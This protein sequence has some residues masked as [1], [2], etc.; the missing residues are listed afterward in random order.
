MRPNKCVLAPWRGPENSTSGSSQIVPSAC[1]VAVAVVYGRLTRF[2]PCSSCVSSKVQK[3]RWK[4]TSLPLWHL[5]PQWGQAAHLVDIQGDDVSAHL[6]LGRHHG[7]FLHFIPVGSQVGQPEVVVNKLKTAGKK[8]SIVCTQHKY[9]DNTWNTS[10]YPFH[11][12]RSTTINPWS[13]Y[14]LMWWNSPIAAPLNFRSTYSP[15]SFLAMW[16]LVYKI[17]I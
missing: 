5:S 4:T 15:G 10:L 14:V 2:F 9:E 16:K 1:I 12:H 17:N 13:S 11:A 3:V 6:R 8:W 7:R